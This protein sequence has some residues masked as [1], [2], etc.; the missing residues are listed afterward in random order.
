MPSRFLI[1]LIAGLPKI[2]PQGKFRAM[3]SFIEREL[4]GFAFRK[5]EDLHLA[6]TNPDWE[7]LQERTRLRQKDFLFDS[8]GFSR[9]V[10][11]VVQG[12]RR[13]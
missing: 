5:F 12:K 1:A 10:N 8:Q 13:W 3:K 2:L 6:L 7:E 4:V 9:F 11:V